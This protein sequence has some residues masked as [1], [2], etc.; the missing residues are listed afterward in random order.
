MSY[1][2][3]VGKLSHHV[4]PAKAGIQGRRNTLAPWI[5]AFAGMTLL[6]VVLIFPKNIYAALEDALPKPYPAPDISGP[7]PWLNSPALTPADLKGK[8][9]LVD[10]WT[11]TCINCLRTLPY[12]RAW[13]ERYKD[14]GFVLLGVH[15]P[16]FEFEKNPANVEKAVKRFKISWPVVQDNDMTIWRRFNN[17][18]WPAHYLI[19]REGQVVYTHFGEGNYD[20]TE[21]NIRTLLAAEGPMAEVKEDAGGPGQR[22][23][24]ELYLGS[25]RGASLIPEGDNIYKFP[26]NLPADQWALN[27]KWDRSNESVE[28]MES[29]AALRLHFYGAKVFLVM[30]SKDKKPVRVKILHNGQPLAEHA[31][32]DVKD[33]VVEVSEQRLYE[34]FERKNGVFSGGEGVIEIQAEQ[35]GL[36]AYAFTFGG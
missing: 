23:T 4:M 14:Q 8:V 26:A 1:L 27:G 36:Q 19:S 17:R 16:E 2:P 30:G 33:G 3:R 34:L 28:A 35:P 25:T 7:G 29:G 20:R 5:P 11:Y 12:L 21:T 32:K 24:P 10:F 31:G 9:V 22:Q 15:S 18:Y 13:H 6:M